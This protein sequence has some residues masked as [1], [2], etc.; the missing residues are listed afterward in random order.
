MTNRRRWQVAAF[1]TLVVAVTP[2]VLIKVAWLAGSD[3]GM[4]PGSGVGVM[5]TPRFIT[6]NIITIGMDVLAVVLGAA[7][8]QP[9]GRRVP[10]WLVFI[11]GGARNGIAGPN[12]SRAPVGQ[13]SSACS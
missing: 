6:G 8:I 3:F 12:P 13:S 5:G 1:C 2:Y 11:V 7:L 4:K 9:W 10:A